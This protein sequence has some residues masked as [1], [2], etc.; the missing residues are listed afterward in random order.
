ML[1]RNLICLSLFFLLVSTKPTAVHGQESDAASIRAAFDSTVAANTY[2]ATIEDRALKGPGADWL[3]A[4]GRE[5]S[6]FLMSE[7]HG[8]AETPVVAASLYERLSEYGYGPVALEIGPFAAQEVNETLGQNGY[9]ALEGLITRFKSPPIAFL[10][11]KAESKMAARMAEAGATIWGVDYEFAFS[12]P[13]HLD[14]LADQAETNRE[15]KAVQRAR[16]KMK[17]EWGGV[18]GRALVKAT[19]SELQSL[20][21]AFESRGDEVALARI[22]AMLESNA[23]YAPYVRDAGN[24]AVSNRRRE[25]LMKE[26]LIRH[27]REWESAREEAPKVFHK[28]AHIDKV[29][30]ID[31][32][33]TFGAFVA[34]WSRG[35][36]EETFH[37]L[38]DCNG[39]QIPE[40]GQ[41]EGG[42]CNARLGGEDSP[43]T[44]H[45]RED[46][47]VVIDLRPLRRY[48]GASFLSSEDRR[49]IVSYDAYVAIPNVSPSDLLNSIGA[50]DD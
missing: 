1:A 19:P 17:G 12:L 5:A 46:K 13:M 29:A 31:L 39:G 24:F 18:G 44:D 33:V 37:V 14:A 34:E 9:Q 20:R 4:R 23:I 42:K 32:H 16:S 26:Q 30:P 38:A 3:V 28:N 27:V 45:L 35:R 6:H 49:R 48:F 36:G 25:A 43:F 21:S 8:T 7:R 41:D 22:D 15:R 40:S 2:T 50:A 10:D 47:V 11:R